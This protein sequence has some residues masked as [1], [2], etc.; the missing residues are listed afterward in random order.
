[1]SNN[2]AAENPGQGDNSDIIRV[3]FSGLPSWPPLKPKSSTPSETT[4]E[5]VPK[6]GMKFP[7]EALSGLAG[8]IVKKLLPETESHAAALLA[9]ILARFGNIVGRTAYHQVEDSKH[10]ANLFFVIVGATSKARKG[11]ANNRIDAIFKGI[12]MNW[13][14]RELGGFGSGE[15]V[16]NA[17]RDEQ[18][19][20]FKG[21]TKILAGVEDKRLLIREGE[22]SKILAVGKREGNL[23]SQVLRDAWDG[24]T[25][26][27]NVKNNPQTATDPHIS[28]VCDITQGELSLRLDQAD[29]YNGFANRFLWLFVERL[30]EKPFGGSDLD[31]TRERQKLRKAVLSARQRERIFTLS[32]DLGGIVGGITGRAEAQVLRLALV[33]ALLDQSDH[34]QSVHLKSALWLWEYAV[35]SVEHLFAK[36]GVMTEEQKKMVELARGVAQSKTDF[37]RLFQKHRKATDI[38]D[39]IQALVAKKLMKFLGYETR[40]GRNVRVWRSI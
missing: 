2:S 27:N 10:Y 25:L 13:E 11:T 21:K 32:K 8:N 26:R 15:G 40:G 31:W 30:R 39:D 9:H 12:D 16:I 37:Y 4:L 29:Q 1:M 6:Y 18:E 34:I 36:H 19:V 3:D 20:G 5:Y 7:D 35:R 17:V 33:Y 23:L 24:K 22:F 28:A 38:E 14:R